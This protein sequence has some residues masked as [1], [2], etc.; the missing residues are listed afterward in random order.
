M[1]HW[2]QLPLKMKTVWRLSAIGS[3]IAWLVILAILFVCHT[4]WHWPLWIMAVILGLGVIEVIVELVIIPYRY[5]FWR[6]HI[7][8]KAVEIERGFF[9]HKQTA[10][11]I[12][13]IQNVTLEAG[14]LLQWQQ[15][16]AVSIETASTT[17][18]IEAVLPHTAEHLKQQIIALAQEARDDA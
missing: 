11:P 9:F 15:L 14:P 16:K 13:R 1:S 12:N 4:I 17:H 3:A 6:Y 18:E 7:A 5:R 10:I 2:E 8:D